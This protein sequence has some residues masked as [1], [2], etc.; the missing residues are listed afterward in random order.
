M[1]DV[2]GFQLFFQLGVGWHV[3]FSLIMG[4]L[5]AT[6][7]LCI[8]KLLDLFFTSLSF[9][10]QNVLSREIPRIYPHYYFCKSAK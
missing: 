3:L 8:I 5:F 4:Q 2:I 6:H 1:P 7:T 10:S 9:A